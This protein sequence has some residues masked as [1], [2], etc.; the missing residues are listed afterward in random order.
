[1]PAIYAIV[2]QFSAANTCTKG[3]NIVF[4]KNTALREKCLYSE[5]CW[6]TSSRIRTEYN[7]PYLSV[8]SLN[9]G[10]YGPEWHVIT[11]TFH[12][13]LVCL[14]NSHCILYRSSSPR[15]SVIKVLLEISQNSQKNTCARFSFWIKLRT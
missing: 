7:A 3:V 2:S 12:A 9:A 1:M 4:L 13:V 15:R 11:Y 10:E 6:S 14:G 5:L 8:F